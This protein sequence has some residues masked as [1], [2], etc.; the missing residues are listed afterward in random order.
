[1]KVVSKKS[2]S[3]GKPKNRMAAHR[4]IQKIVMKERQEVNKL[5]NNIQYQHSNIVHT[6]QVQSKEHSDNSISEKKD[7]LRSWAIRHNVTKRTVNALLKILREIGLQWL[8]RDSRSLCRT[9]RKVVLVPMCGGQYWHHGL[10]INLQR[11]FAKLDENITVELNFNVDGIPL[12][13]SSGTEFWP[14]M[15]NIHSKHKIPITM[16][17]YLI[18]NQ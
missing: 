5:L 17:L 6:E 12:F 1:M 18:K 15:A 2:K 14:I 3:Y 10:A 13:K 8:P 4:A 7:K 16:L 9:P 11:I